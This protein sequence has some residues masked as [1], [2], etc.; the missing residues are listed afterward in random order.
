MATMALIMN[1]ESFKRQYEVDVK[2][3]SMKPMRSVMKLCDKL[4]R[5][6]V[7]MAQSG[8]AYEPDRALS[9]KQAAL[10]LLNWHENWLIRRISR[11]HGVPDCIEQK[12]PDP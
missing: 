2:T 5:L 11:L 3:K 4:A 9:V 10:P 7:A 12:G 8:K 6:L 1:D